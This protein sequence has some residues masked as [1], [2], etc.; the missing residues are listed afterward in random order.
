LLSD[1]IVKRV[2]CDNEWSRDIGCV[3]NC[4]PIWIRTIWVKP[5]PHA[6][7]ES[8]IGVSAILS[9]STNVTTY[10][11]T[12]L[13][14]VCE[15][16]PLNFSLRRTTSYRRPSQCQLR[17]ILVWQNK[18]AAQLPVSS[19]DFNVTWQMTQYQVRIWSCG[20]LRSLR[21]KNAWNSP[22]LERTRWRC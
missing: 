19:T 16:V 12:Y 4:D 21:S 7:F 22:I 8:P 17:V 3:L 20:L 5:R 18:M 6:T 2:I 10:L 11:L 14:P 1:F 15:N 9:P 13:Q